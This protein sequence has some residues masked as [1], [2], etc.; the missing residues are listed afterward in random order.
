MILLIGTFTSKSSGVYS[1][2]EEL[3]G[4]LEVSGY[5]VVLVSQKSSRFSRLAD[6]LGTIWRLRRQFQLAQVDVYSGTAFVWA[7]TA[8]WLLRLLNKP[9]FLVLRGG[10][11]PA[12]AQKWPGRVRRLL[13]AAPVVATPSNY[14]S[15]QLK[16]FRPDFLYLPNPVETQKY[17]FRLREKPEPHL[18]WLRAFHAIYNPSLI[19]QVISLLAQ[20]YPQVSIEMVGPDK[21][22]GSLQQMLDLAGKLGVREQINI[23][24]AVPKEKVPETLNSGDIFLNTTNYDNTPVSVI[25][26]MACGLPIVSTNVGGLPYLLENEKD[27][28]LVTPDDAEKMAQAVERLLT[29]PGL[30]GN[31][32]LAARR[33][34]KGFDWAVVLP[35]WL[36]IFEMVQKTGPQNQRL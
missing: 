25:E 20:K 11:L 13:Q 36:E 34:A 28:L 29:E 15:E 9:Y 21:G 12:F 33:K 7:E 35:Q 1:V 24:G 32:S 16:L 30:A 6:I 14:L 2:G 4:K 5:P 3:A 22:D 27:S 10:N 19:P 8:C 31:L 23:C 26:A 17:P 18:I